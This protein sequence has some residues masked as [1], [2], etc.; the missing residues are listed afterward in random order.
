MSWLRQGVCQ[1]RRLESAH[2][3][4]IQAR[5]KRLAPGSVGAKLLALVLPILDRL[6]A[7]AA[8]RAE[9][10][11]PEEQERPARAEDREDRPRPVSAPG[12]LQGSE[13]PGLP[14]HPSHRMCSKGVWAWCRTCGASTQGTKYSDLKRPCR[15]P[16]PGGKQALARV[17]LG[18]P[19]R[20][21]AE[22]GEPGEGPAW[23]AAWQG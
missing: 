3:Q 4:H 19:P 17:K 21:G 5:T 22:W 2:R 14:L 1:G 6:A 9:E 20:H 7:A 10:S 16:T 8:E 23:P 12:G 15:A 11:E 13:A 18:R